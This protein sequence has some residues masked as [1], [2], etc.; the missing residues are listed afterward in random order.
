MTLTPP[1]ART[2][3]DIDV[4][5]SS[6]AFSVRPPGQPPVEGRFERWTGHLLLDEL[7]LERSQVEIRIEGASVNTHELRRDAQGRRSGFPSSGLAPT[8]TFRSTRIEPAPQDHYRMV[9][10]LTMAMVRGTV[11]LDVQ[12]LA[13]ATDPWGAERAV[14]SVTS[15]VDWRDYGGAWNR[16]PET[17]GLRFGEQIQIDITAE[18]VRR[19]DG[20][21]GRSA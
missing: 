17:E 11:I 1:A 16:T 13:H 4:L 9:G 18:T 19:P 5:H 2:H 14:Y 20:R 10:D 15:S 12:P 7:R 6:L 3:W 8:I 21:K